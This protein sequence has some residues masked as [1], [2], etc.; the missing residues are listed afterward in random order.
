M[1]AG[2]S[3]RP[4]GVSSPPRW[5]GLHAEYSPPKADAEVSAEPGRRSE[6]RRPH[7]VNYGASRLSTP[8]SFIPL[9]EN[10][11]HVLHA[12]VREW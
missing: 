8:V 4:A 10:G 7:L 9:P 5:T 11:E 12:A 1:E 6:T 2:G 3:S